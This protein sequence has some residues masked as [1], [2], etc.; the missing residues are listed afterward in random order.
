MSPVYRQSYLISW[1]IY[2]HVCFTIVQKQLFLWMNLKVNQIN[3][4]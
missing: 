2:M 3:R 1:Y 4:V